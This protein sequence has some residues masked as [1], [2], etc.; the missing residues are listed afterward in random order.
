MPLRISQASGEQALGTEGMLDDIEAALQSEINEAL[1]AVYD[2]L[3]PRDEV[4][5]LRRGAFLRAAGAG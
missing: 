5:A 4:R 2:F 1:Q 3:E